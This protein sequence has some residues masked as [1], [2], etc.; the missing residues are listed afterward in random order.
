[1]PEG[2]AEMTSAPALPGL[3]LTDGAA[4]APGGEDGGRAVTFG[5]AEAND[6]TLLPE[7]FRKAI[8]LA[9][10]EAP[11]RTPVKLGPDDLQ[12]YRIEGFQPAGS[13]RQVTVYASPTSEG[14]ATVACL[15]PPADAA[16]FKPRVRGDRRHAGDHVRN[17]VPGRT[18]PAYAKTL[19]TTLGR[20]DGQ[21]AKGRKAIARDKTTFRAQAAAARDIQAAYVAAAKK[22]RN[23]ET[24]P[25]DTLI[26]ALLADRLG[27]AAGAWKKAAAAAAKKDK[28]GFARSAAAI[29]RTQADLRLALTGLEKVGYKV[30]G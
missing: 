29:K 20:L 24:S 2:Y 5:R 13:S 11:E 19:S 28:A 12:A 10:G 26:N 4:F 18:R 23:T 27:A 1:M 21:V 30:A 7:Q 15:A 16:A 25:A 22:L 14:V 17:A 3:D 8:G 9:A 6:S